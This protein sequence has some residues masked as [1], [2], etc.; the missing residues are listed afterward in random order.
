MTAPLT[1]LRERDRLLPKI[2][3]PRHIK[4][5]V[6]TPQ[7]TSEDPPDTLLESVHFVPVQRANFA[8]HFGSVQ[9]FQIDFSTLPPILSVSKYSK[10]ISL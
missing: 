4:I 1:F 9:I 8:S 7:S 5:I 6:N 3:T 10:Y 2:T